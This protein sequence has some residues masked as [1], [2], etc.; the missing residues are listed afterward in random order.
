MIEFYKDNLVP[1]EL[2]KLLYKVVPRGYHTPVRF[3]NRRRKDLYGELG[4]SPLGSVDLPR[5]K[6]PSAI[7]INLNPIY[8]ASCK[9]GHRFSALAPSSA[10]WRLLLETCLHEFGHVATKREVFRMNHHEYHG[11]HGHVYEAIERLA[12]EWM[13][14]QIAK[15]VRVDPRLGQPRYMSGYLGARLVKWRKL[16]KDE[17]GYYPFIMERR[18]QMTGGQLTA[19]DVLRH[20]N[21][22]AR[23]YTNAYAILRQVSENI[24]ID[25]TD[26][27]GRRHKLYTWGDVPI[28]ARRFQF[29]NLRRKTR[30][31]E[32]VGDDAHTLAVTAAL[33]SHLEEGGW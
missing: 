14:H 25:Y 7:D 30:A 32:S 12:N 28:L 17:P 33:G 8:S 18:C 4:R 16:I 24:G 19:G 15:I 20:M 3:H 10:I 11:S 27:A 26:R 31:A 22:E 21:V 5:H 9:D 29:A 1:P 13:E 2:C 23:S 6:K